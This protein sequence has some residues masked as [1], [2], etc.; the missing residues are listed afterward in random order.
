M[1]AD[2]GAPP[3]DTRAA[4]RRAAAQ[5][6]TAATRATGSRVAE[7]TATRVR[8]GSDRRPTLT[9]VNRPSTMVASHLPQYRLYPGLERLVD[10]TAEVEGVANLHQHEAVEEWHDGT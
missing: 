2:A 7:R 5:L 4:L 10:I 6:S 3:P 1:G 9:Q 8:L